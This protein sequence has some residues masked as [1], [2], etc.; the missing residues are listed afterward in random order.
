VA[1]KSG[2]LVR[3]VG[4]NLRRP[5]MCHDMAITQSYSILMDFPLWDMAGPTRIE[6]RSRF[7]ILPRHAASEQEIRWFEGVGLYGYHTANCWES[8]PTAITLVMVAALGFNFTRSNANLLKLR[9]FVFDLSSGETTEQDLCN[10]PCEFPIVD[11]RLV[12]L[13]AR[14]IYASTLDASINEPLPIN[15][16]LQHDLATGKSKQVLFPGGRRGGELQF[17][18]RRMPNGVLSDEGDG[19]LLM[20]AF[21]PSTGAHEL[22]IFDAGMCNGAQICVAA[23]SIP[24]RVPYG[25]HALWVEQEKF[26]TTQT[27]KSS[28]KL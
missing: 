1:D 9:S 12:G 10:I 8:S 7:G 19:Y 5:V 17:V 28:S 11:Q 14:F 20:F 13:Q 24:H 25:F 16:F 3:T 2:N 21:T 15:G 23:I 27:S 18:P 26:E 4:V 6:D 22:M